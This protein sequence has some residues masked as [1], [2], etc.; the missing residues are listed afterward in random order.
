MLHYCSTWHNLHNSSVSL[1]FYW[2]GSEFLNKINVGV[3]DPT[4]VGI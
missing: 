2:F 4:S 1:V 3:K